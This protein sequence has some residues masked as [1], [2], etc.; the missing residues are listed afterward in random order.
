M[1]LN[2]NGIAPQHRGG[3]VIFNKNT[4]RYYNFDA[5]A[6][7]VW[8]YIQYPR[9]LGEIRNAIVEN[10]DMESDYSERDVRL[11]LEQMEEEGFIETRKDERP[12]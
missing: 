9:T 12:S 8:Q 2:T 7:F 11:L 5:L 6:A 4:R 10:F 3:L 1:A